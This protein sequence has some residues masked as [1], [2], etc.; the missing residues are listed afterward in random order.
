MPRGRVTEAD[1]PSLRGDGI[2]LETTNVHSIKISD[3]GKIAFTLY[4]EN[5]VLTWPNQ[6]FRIEGEEFEHEGQT[7]EDA[8]FEH[9]PVPFGEYDLIVGEGRFRVPAIAM[10]APPHPV[11]VPWDALY[12]PSEW[13]GPT[14]DEL[15]FDPDADETSEDS[16]AA[17]NPETAENPDATGEEL[18]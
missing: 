18:S 6:A 5:G 1:V 7:D 12:D 2:R 3:V 4:S 14:E 16:E 17:E 15:S 10:G 8:R 11:H 9:S 13:P